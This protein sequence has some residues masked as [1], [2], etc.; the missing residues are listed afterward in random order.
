MKSK[1]LVR[2]DRIDI[3]VCCC[4]KHHSYFI[5]CAC[6][7]VWMCMNGRAYSVY[8][9]TCVFICMSVCV[10][11]FYQYILTYSPPQFITPKRYVPC[12]TLP[13]LP[14]L[15]RTPGHN[16]TPFLCSVCGTF[17]APL[18]SDSQII[19]KYVCAFTWRTF[20]GTFC[21]YIEGMFFWFHCV[22]NFVSILPHQE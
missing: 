18:S 16:S 4:E 5:A 1:P 22:Q 8:M 3:S 21:M 2:E 14:F 11:A 12:L 17:N 20:Q 6:V 7:S 19:S 15:A 9:Y 10:S 13:R